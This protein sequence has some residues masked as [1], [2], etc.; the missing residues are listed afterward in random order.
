MTFATFFTDTSIAQGTGMTN[1]VSGTTTTVNLTSPVSPAHG[2]TGVTNGTNTLTVNANSTINQ[3][4]STTASPTFVNVDAGNWVKGTTSVVPVSGTTTLTNTSTRVQILLSGGTG[5]QTYKLPD[6]TTLSIGWTFEFNNNATGNLLIVDNA[7][8]AIETVPPGAYVEVINLSVSFPAGQWDKHWL[9]PANA[10]Y[11]T[12][13]MAV[14][15]FASATGNASANNFINGYQAIATANATTTFTVS[16]PGQVYFTGTNNQTVLMPVVSTLVLGQSWVIVNNSRGTVTVE[17]SGSNVIQ[18][19]ASGS[20]AIFTCILTSGTDATSWNVEYALSA[21]LSLNALSLA[22][23]PTGGST[24]P[25]SI[26]L[27][28]GQ[29]A[30]SGASLGLAPSVSTVLADTTLDTSQI[31]GMHATPISIL[32][33]LPEGSQYYIESVQFAFAN[34]NPF[35]DG[36]DVYFQYGSANGATNVDATQRLPVASFIDLSTPTDMT[37]QWTLQG[38]FSTN[39]ANLTDGNVSQSG[40]GLYITNATAPFT[41]GDST[42]TNVFV[43]GYIYAPQI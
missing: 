37:P 12:A 35:A 39:T 14:T 3:N 25:S 36:G 43:I 5:T 34:T 32:G 8:G 10:N 23:N 15:G 4:V 38:G 22:G 19:V 17:S 26:G 24:F 11:G 28:S 21:P 27:V 2:G 6:A 16:T 30:F 40:V 33:A 7:T 42:T 41:G 18:A 31:T 9:M 1:S 20:Y 29:L 13:G